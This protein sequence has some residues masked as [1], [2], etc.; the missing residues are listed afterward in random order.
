[1]VKFRY[2]SLLPGDALHAMGERA[3]AGKQAVDQPVLGIRLDDLTTWYGLP[4]PNHIKLDV[5]GAELDI[6]H[7]AAQALVYAGLRTM[8][9]ELNEEDVD[10]EQLKRCLSD[11]GLHLA[12]VTKRSDSRGPAYGL[13]VRQESAAAA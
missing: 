11:S 4:L 10:L 3:V 13:F 2:H 1:M 6:L 8:M 12:T 9:A 7:G 5:D